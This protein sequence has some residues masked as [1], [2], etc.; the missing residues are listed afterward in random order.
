[1]VLGEASAYDLV[2]GVVDVTNDA[3]DLYPV[4][5]TIVTFT[6]VD[7]QGNKYQKL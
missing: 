3:P 6:A 4:G 1:V 7:S 2:D 5:T